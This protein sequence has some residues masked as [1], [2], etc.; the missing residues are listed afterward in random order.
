MS[1]KAT[2]KRAT[3]KSRSVEIT[4]EKRSEEITHPNLFPHGFRIIFCVPEGVMETEVLQ[5]EQ[6]SGERK[7]KD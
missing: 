1:G 6:I 7:N 2:A 5:N 3:E 4:E